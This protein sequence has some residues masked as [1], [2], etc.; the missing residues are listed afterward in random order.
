MRSTTYSDCFF[1]LKQFL[2]LIS[3]SSLVTAPLPVSA[4]TRI[5]GDATLPRSTKVNNLNSGI[6]EITG[7]SRPENAANLFHSL[8]EFSIQSGDTARFTHDAAIKNILTRVTGGSASNINGT[9]Q[10]WIDGVTPSTANL[11]LIN[12]Q[13][14]I[15]GSDAVLDIGGSFIGSTAEKI[16]FADG[17][18]FNAINSSS[19]PL[20]TITAPIGLQFGSNSIGSINIDGNGN[21]IKVN[22]DFSINTSN[23]PSGLNYKNSN[24][25]STGKTVALI[26]NEIILDGG[27]ITFPGGKVELWSVNQGEISL[28]E[29]NSNLEFKANQEIEYGNINLIN[30]ASINTSGNSGGS[31]Q[32]KGK[33]ISLQDASVIISDT[34]GSGF[35]GEINIAASESIAVKGFALQPNNQVFSSILADVATGASGNGGKINLNTKILQVE[36]GAQISSGTFGSGNAGELNIKAEDIQMSG[37]SVFG[38]SLI[39][40]PVAPGA[41]GNGGTLTIETDSLK[42]TNAAQIF[43]S[44]FG[45]GKA[46]DLKITAENIEVIG[47]IPNGASS[48]VT[49]VEIILGMPP[50]LADF[51]GVGK[52]TGANLNIKTGSLK[53]SDGAQISV[54][55]SGSGKAGNLKVE[56]DSVELTG[57]NPFGLSGLLANATRS[58]GEGG[59]LNLTTDKLIIRNRATINAGNFL[60]SDPDNLRGFAGSGAAGNINV[61]SPFILLENQGTITANTNAGDKG[62]INIESQN[63]QLF[64]ESSITSNAANS[65]NGGNILIDTDTL[66][67]LQN[68][69][70]TAN[71]TEGFGGQVTINAQGIFGIKQRSE[72]TPQSDITAS[73]NRGTQFNGV[74]ELNT[75]DIDPNSGV[76]NLPTTVVDADNNVNAGCVAQQGNNFLI[77]NRGGLP[78]NP[79]TILRGV[80]LWSDLRTASKKGEKVSNASIR[81]S[82]P[83]IVEAT[84]W[85]RNKKGELYLVANNQMSNGVYNQSAYQALSCSGG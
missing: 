54:R 55:T 34:L 62:N 15:F 22:Q 43:S 79:T 63:L 52:G 46:G 7:G 3:I 21:N 73:S 69:D 71:A 47:G 28:V 80:N 13:G 53:V 81:N 76:N 33:N 65:S 66:V 67:G 38:P 35:G 56:A 5:S 49:A 27:N 32:I 78:Y 51:L 4:Q 17:A 74:V 57:S 12:P 70:I 29:D 41:T 37:F 75:P 45:F 60:S 9:I 24:Q 16:K 18:E 20:L 14:I 2:L 10:T 72:L 39:A 50:E 68:S 44:T 30:A 83:A 61:N 31:I 26:A 42:I 58:N 36:D 48:I 23:R 84:G 77:S 1:G 8:K 85:V 6:Y 64:G 11:F 19:Q 82:K 40:T 25:N 59:D